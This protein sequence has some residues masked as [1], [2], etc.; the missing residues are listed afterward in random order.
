MIPN[1]YFAT[2]PRGLEQLLADELQEVK[3]KSIKLTDGG[4]IFA[5]AQ[6]IVRWHYQWIVIHEFL[7]KTC[8]EAMVDDILQNG[9]VLISNYDALVSVYFVVAVIYVLI[10][11]AIN[12]ASVYAARRSGTKIIARTETDAGKLL[13]L[14][15]AF[16]VLGMIEIRQGGFGTQMRTAKL[17]VVENADLET[18]SAQPLVEAKSNGGFAPGGQPH[19]NDV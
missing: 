17:T 15:P 19:H 18:F 5:E 13:A 2:C 11:Y 12:Q 1:R 3:A 10:N 14:A 16:L 8:G 9:R 4:E 7:K 6:R